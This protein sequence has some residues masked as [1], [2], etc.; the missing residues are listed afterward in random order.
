[1]VIAGAGVTVISAFTVAEGSVTD[2]AVMVTGEPG[3]VGGAV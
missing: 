3:G 1:M 2:A